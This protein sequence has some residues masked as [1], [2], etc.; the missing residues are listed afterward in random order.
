[1]Q[2]FTKLKYVNCYVACPPESPWGQIRKTK[3]FQFFLKICHLHL[4]ESNGNVY[5]RSPV[6]PE[7]W[8][9]LLELSTDSL[10]DQEKY[11]QAA[12][13]YY[14][15]GI[16]SGRWSLD[17]LLQKLRSDQI[18]HI[19]Q[20]LAQW[21]KRFDTSLVSQA[22]SRKPCD[23]PKTDSQL[24]NARETWSNLPHSWH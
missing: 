1:M 7:I 16:L 20:V 3:L 24:L 9:I 4:E 2:T 6:E 15:L 17:W 5:C 19:G 23:R 12:E 22:L 21:S 13:R 8:E 14:L 11:Q 10:T 18:V